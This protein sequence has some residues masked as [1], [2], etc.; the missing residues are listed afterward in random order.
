MFERFTTSARQCVVLAQYEARDLGHG[1]IG[2]EHLL[3]AI[4]REPHG[5]G[6]RL[7]RDLGMTPENGRADALRIIGPEALDR[8]ALASIGIDLDE[9]RRRAE[10]T[11][12]P[13]ALE[14]A[15]RRGCDEP[16]P[17]PFT[18]RSKKALELSV[19]FAAQLGD[20]VIGSE[21]LL[22]GIAGVEEGVGAQVLAER[23]L[24]RE[25]LEAAVERAHRAA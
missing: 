5:L 19:R 13:G 6:G 21:H 15:G 22:L 10:E 14:G 23:G 25:Q 11:F 12:G 1:W 3:I 24:T 17:P 9:V 16:G 18:K 7:L 20:N 2:T 4:A 8:D